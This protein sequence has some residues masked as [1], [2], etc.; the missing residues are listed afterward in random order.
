MPT[1]VRPRSYRYA[2]AANELL[3][4]VQQP[5]HQP[6]PK[7]FLSTFDVNWQ[8]IREVAMLDSG[9]SSHVL[10]SDAP[11]T[12]KQIATAPITV[13]H[14]DGD[15]TTSTYDDNLDLPQL[16]RAARRCHILPAIKQSLISVVKCCEAGCEVKF[17]KWGVRIEI[18]YRGR[19]VLEGALNK[20]TGLWMVH[21]TRIFTPTVIKQEASNTVHAR[22]S[23]PTSVTNFNKVKSTAPT[24]SPAHKS[25]TAVAITH[26][27]RNLLVQDFTNSNYATS[28]T[29][30]THL[31]SN[32]QA[33]CDKQPPWQS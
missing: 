25:P 29:Q 20:R 11:V 18:R 15:T 23:S 2:F 12:D 28:T 1:R 6:A 24:S 17:I 31:L 14:L 30:S 27:L 7:M 13:I 32:L 4:N 9:A 26:T 21:I 3:A 10:C 16:P 33:T 8:N 5:S 19:I 22:P